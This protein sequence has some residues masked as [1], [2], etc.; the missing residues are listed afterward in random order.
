VSGDSIAREVDDAL[1][2]VARDVGDGS[3]LVTLKTPAGGSATPWGT[4]ADTFTESELPAMVSSYPFDMI[5]GT[6]IRATDKRVMVSAVGAV[7]TTADKLEIDGVDHAI[8]MVK[9]LAPSGVPLFYECQC[10]A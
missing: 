3:F 5:D 1:R 8:V 10:R 7:P 9:P 4:T 2:E 6:L